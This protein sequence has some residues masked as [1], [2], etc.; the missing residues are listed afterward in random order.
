MEK[1]NTLEIF[2]DL[3]KINYT[4]C[5]ITSSHNTVYDYNVCTFKL[6]AIDIM[7]SLHFFND[8]WKDHFQDE[9]FDL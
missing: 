9:K 1:Q 2:K 5:I 6:E 8:D 7:F 3:M 4:N